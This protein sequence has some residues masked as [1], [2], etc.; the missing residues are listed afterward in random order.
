MPADLSPFFFQP[1]PVNFAGPELLATISGI[2]AK[3]AEQ[4]VQTRETRGFFTRPQDLLAVP[5][6]GPSRMH[7]FAP[8]FSFN[9]SQ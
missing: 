2:G 3:T 4:I 6:I 8:Q 7:K 5:G 1:I 9:V